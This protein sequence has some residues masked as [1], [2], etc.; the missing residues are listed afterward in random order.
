MK[1]NPTILKRSK[2]EHVPDPFRSISKS[3][4]L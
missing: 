3:P 4:T 2:K 1:F